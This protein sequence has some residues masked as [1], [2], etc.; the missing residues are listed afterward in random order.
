MKDFKGKT[1]VITGAGSGI[2]RALASELSDLGCNLALSDI[3]EAG[4]VETASMLNGTGRV[5]TWRVD[6]SDRLAMG[7]FASDAI[8]AFGAVDIVINNAGVALEGLFEDN[9]Y[10]ELEWILG[11]NLWGVIHGCKEFIPHLKTRP[12][13][14]LVNI[15]S[16]FGIL[17]VPAF[18]AYQISK[19]GVRG[20]TEALRQEL[21]GTGIAVTCVHPGGIKTSIARN[22]RSSTK[23]GDEY[24]EFV[25]AYEKNFIT[26][27]ESAAKTIVRGI[28]K[29]Q[30]R[31]LVGMDAKI[32]DRVARA[33]PGSYERVVGLVSD[34]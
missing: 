10:D 29:K 14:S 21:K 1:A 27:A 31:V 20:L 25:D 9:S 24:E 7:Q 11:V 6:V 4:L 32:F 26:T 16:L 17:T 34:L 22:L 30:A 19:F 28:R 15:S 12:E 5:E 18:S 13:A 2:G 3:D 33:M 23:Q 8:A